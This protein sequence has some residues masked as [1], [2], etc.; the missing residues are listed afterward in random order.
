V[1][2]RKD[3]RRNPFEI[4]P[5][6]HTTTAILRYSRR[7]RTINNGELEDFLIQNE[8]VMYLEKNNNKLIITIII[9]LLLVFSFQLLLAVSSHFSLHL[10]KD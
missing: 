1:R 6:F 8:K 9:F 7:R 2:T 5:S 4:P 3:T 10:R